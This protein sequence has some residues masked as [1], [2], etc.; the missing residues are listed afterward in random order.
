MTTVNKW[1]VCER[2]PKVRA[3]RKSMTTLTT[4]P[5]LF[6]IWFPPGRCSQFDDS[7]DLTRHPRNWNNRHNGYRHPIRQTLT[8]SPRACR[9]KTDTRTTRYR[10]SIRCFYRCMPAKLAK[11]SMWRTSLA[12]ATALARFPSATKRSN[13]IK[14]AASTAWI[15][16]AFTAPGRSLQVAAVS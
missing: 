15:N 12:A 9:S 4:W 3:S 14:T 7:S 5:L 13:S 6:A 8:K 1:P 10:G 11:S 16:H 2:L